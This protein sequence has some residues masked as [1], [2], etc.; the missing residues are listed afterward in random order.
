MIEVVR[1]E[2]VVSA[3]SSLASHIRVVEAELVVFQDAEDARRP[4]RPG[5]PDRNVGVPAP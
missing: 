2:E 5:A 4:A 3:S 1:V